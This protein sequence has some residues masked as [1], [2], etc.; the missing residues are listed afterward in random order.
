MACHTGALKLGW[1]LR[2]DP[3]LGQGDG[4]FVP[5]HQLV[6]TVN[7]AVHFGGETQLWALSWQHSWQLGECV[8]S[9]EGGI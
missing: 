5:P 4:A 8:P 2:V 7:E 3:P 9:P 1:L 6:L